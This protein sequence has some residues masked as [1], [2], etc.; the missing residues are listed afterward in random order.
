[1]KYYCNKGLFL[2]K[3]LV[4]RVSK[5]TKVRDGGLN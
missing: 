5:Y 4:D 2:D 3:I 1:M